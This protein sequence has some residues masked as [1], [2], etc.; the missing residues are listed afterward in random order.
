M[1]FIKSVV[2]AST[3]SLALVGSLAACASGHSSLVTASS[4]AARPAPVAC[5]PPNDCAPTI[6]T[7]CERPGGLVWRIQEQLDSAQTPRDD[8]HIWRELTT[9][10]WPYQLSAAA[11]QVA[12]DI[13][14]TDGPGAGV[15]WSASWPASVGGSPSGTSQR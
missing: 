7:V 9:T 2:V 12:H 8:E 14:Y 10:S 4:A 3:L 5:A 11:A 1:R 15:P 6:S 13:S